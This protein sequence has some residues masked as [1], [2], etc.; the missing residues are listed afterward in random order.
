MITLN[1]V[2]VVVDLQQDTHPAL[3]RALTLAEKARCSLT[4]VCCIHSNIEELP[5]LVSDAEQRELK[6]QS[7][8]YYLEQLKAL[9]HHPSNEIFSLNYEVICNASVSRGL[10]DYLREHKFD[11]VI[12]TVHEH[13][14]RKINRMTPTDWQLMREPNTPILLVRENRWPNRS[15]ILGAIDI[16]AKD[17]PHQLLNTRII[18]YSI[19]LSKLLEAKPHVVSVFPWPLIELRQFKHLF[20]EEGYYKEG[21]RIHKKLLIN[22][23][24][25]YSFGEEQ[26]HIAEGLKPH[27]TLPAIV[28]AT[29]SQL[30]ILGTVGRKGLAGVLLGNTA[31]HIL[32]N[33]Q[34]EVLAVK[35]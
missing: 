6:Q 28:R 32:D 10:I 29:Q 20:D 19:Y 27:E 13:T 4:L 8:N 9:Y 18:D 24:K 16:Q 26:I 33:L 35:N 5:P 25:S 30:I 31:E 14:H 23:V 22:F 11:L 15:N 1:S 12:K 3:S 21:K 7:I 34:C 17:K 2:L